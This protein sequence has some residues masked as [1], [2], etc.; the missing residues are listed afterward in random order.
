[1]KKLLSLFLALLMC[2]ALLPAT[3]AEET[4]DVDATQNEVYDE[5]L[6]HVL[7]N[8]LSIEQEP[9]ASVSSSFLSDCSA[10]YK[11][12]QYYKNLAALVFSGNQASDI[13][14]V[15]NSQIGYHESNSSSDFSGESNGS[16]NY[17]EYNRWYFQNT[18]NHQAWCNLFVSWCRAA[19]GISTSVSP[20]NPFYL[21]KWK[22][23]GAKV[24]SWKDFAAGSV[25]P[26]AGDIIIF[27]S[28]TTSNIAGN[29]LSNS[30]K[31]IGIITG[32]SNGTFNTVE[33]NTSDQVKPKTYTPNSNTGYISSSYY[34]HAIVQPTYNQCSHDSYYTSEGQCRKCGAWLP[35]QN[36]NYS[37]TAGTY[38]VKSG[39]TAYLREGHPYQIATPYITLSVG[40]TVWVYGCVLNGFGNKWYRCSYNSKEYWCV[41]GNLE[42]KTAASSDLKISMPATNHTNRTGIPAGDLVQGQTWN[43]SGSI[44]SSYY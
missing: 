11:S 34:V 30:T 31:H 37:Y 1:M 24:Y 6:S 25:T 43:L 42:L 35:N 9:L 27:G 38:A 21:D 39:K 26:K 12:G 5:E 28:S 3:M 10:S 14:K 17:T 44:S 16:D 29:D 15:A 13:V 41:A 8:P 33:G 36:D 4:G 2:F 7:E 32:Y 23:C 18:S 19:A 22:E 20:K 40:Q